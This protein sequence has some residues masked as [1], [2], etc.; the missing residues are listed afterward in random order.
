MK[1]IIIVVVSVIGYMIA[2][3][4]MGEAKKATGNYLEVMH[5]GAKK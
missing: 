5:G 4:N 2:T 1:W 3:Q